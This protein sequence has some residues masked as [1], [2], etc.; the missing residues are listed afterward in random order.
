MKTHDSNEN[1]P[2]QTVSKG[3][4]YTYE[5]YV[6][7]IH[8]FH[9]EHGRAPTWTEYASLEGPTPQAIRYRPEDINDY[10]ELVESLGYEPQQHSTFVTGE[11]HPYWIPREE[12]I[13]DY[14]IGTAI[15]NRPPTYT[16]IGHYCEYSTRTY[17][18]R[19]GS[20]ENIRDAAGVSEY[21][22]TD[23]PKPIREFMELLY[24]MEAVD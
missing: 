9:K 24:F 1:K 12:L 6:D 11:D 10:R 16:E 3:N 20:V 4:R 21:D 17:M 13:E 22:P 8:D 23:P 5:E 15:L 19:F 14:Q 18:D 7:P 2:D